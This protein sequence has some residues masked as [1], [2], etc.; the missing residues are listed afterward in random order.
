MN[1][2]DISQYMHQIYEYNMSFF[3]NEDNN[4]YYLLGAFITDGCVY[5]NGPNTYACQIS[6]CDIDWLNKI[7]NLIGTN[8]KLHQFKANYY[9]IRI[10]R[11]EIANWFIVHGCTP[12]K[13]YNITL[14]Y[15][16]DIYFK[17]FVRGCIDG[18]G[19]LGEYYSNKNIK[20]SCQIISAS[21]NFLE[22][23]QI[24]LKSFLIHTTITNRGKQNSEIN[25]KQII[26]KTNSYSLN[27]YGTNC[28]KLLQ[29]AY[30]NNHSI[31]LERKKIIANKIIDHYNNK[32]IMDLRKIPKL[33]KGC[34]IQWPCDDDLIKMIRAT[35]CSQVAKEL[36]VHNTAVRSRL[37][38]RGLYPIPK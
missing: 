8:L 34:K 38:R 6:S 22:Q 16:P 2:G 9:G 4:S 10:T 19:S 3:N 20:H 29:F 12:Q 32:K 26:A 23:L 14:P 11:N 25:G 30:Y 37:K 13:T 17:D 21:K 1:Y 31:S 27:A 35:N 15:I 18:D 36:G 33:N 7:K 5:K 28:F 24:K